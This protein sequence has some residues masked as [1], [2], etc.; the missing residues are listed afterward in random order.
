MSQVATETK[1]ECNLG[2]EERTRSKE[3]KIEKY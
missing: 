3:I 2:L 1:R